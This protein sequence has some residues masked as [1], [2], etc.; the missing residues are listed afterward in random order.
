MSYSGRVDD[1][2]ETGLNDST[3]TVRK[4]HAMFSEES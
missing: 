4:S 2:L 1:L 3:I